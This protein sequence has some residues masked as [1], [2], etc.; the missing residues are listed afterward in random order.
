MYKKP[1]S[2]KPIKIE[3]SH[4]PHSKKYIKMDHSNSEHAMG[5]QKS[6]YIMIEDDVH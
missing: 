1:L 6:K 5:I 3:S 2:F 4:V